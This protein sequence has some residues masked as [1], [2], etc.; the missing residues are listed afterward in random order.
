MMV[1][2]GFRSYQ[3]CWALRQWCESELS[4]LCGVPVS[5]R[6]DDIVK[7][8]V[9]F[10]YKEGFSN[11][12]RRSVKI[13]DLLNYSGIW[14]RGLWHSDTTTVSWY[15]GLFV[16]LLTPFSL[17][18]RYERFR[19]KKNPVFDAEY[20][21]SMFPRNVTPVYQ[22]WRR[23]YRSPQCPVMSCVVDGY[24]DLCWNTDRSH[25]YGPP[26]RS[27]QVPTICHKPSCNS[28]CWQQQALLAEW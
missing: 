6:K 13:Q 21:G 8:D 1:Y 4:Q 2:T 28:V 23:H 12:V 3:Q 17:V 22:N 27:P 25:G 19:R 15:F 7:S 16:W 9:W 26:P 10:H 14:I 24:K 18:G 20:W 5:E 11:A